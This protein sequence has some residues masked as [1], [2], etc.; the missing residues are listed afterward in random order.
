MLGDTLWATAN[1]GA[2]LLSSLATFFV[3]TRSLGPLE[4]GFY[5]GIQALTG[6][7]FGFSALW[8]VMLLLERATRDGRSLATVFAGALSLAGGGAMVTV[9]IAVLAG[10]RFLPDVPM[11]TIVTFAVAELVGNTVLTV[12]AA[13]VQ[14]GR[15]YAAGAVVRTATVLPRFVSVIGLYLLD[16]VDLGTLGVWQMVISLVLSLLLLVGTSRQLGL[17]LRLARP[18]LRDLR[19]GFPYAGVLATFRLQEDADKALLVRLGPPGVAGLYAAAYRIASLSQL[20]IQALV[21]ASHQR[22]L[23]DTPGVR[24]EHVERT[25][26]YT[27]PALAYS[28]VA[29]VGIFVLAPLVG[30]LLG[31]EYTDAVPILR[32]LAPLALL[33]SLSL[34]GFNSLMGLGRNRDRLLI[35]V[36]SSAVNVVANLALIPAHSWRGSVAATALAEVVFIAGTWGAVVRGQRS[37]DAAVDDA[38]RLDGH[39]P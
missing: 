18:R 10:P 38:Q 9:L 30:R 24:R 20:P 28:V 12:V 39:A 2:T 36:V 13:T 15:G 25:L 29:M 7:L 8:V 16:R 14:V 32:A 22:F 17:P 23:V 1:E 35:V 33:R 19:D 6:T 26:R 37:R 27:V 31:P 34:F 3:L 4:Y 5:A 11:A 21:S